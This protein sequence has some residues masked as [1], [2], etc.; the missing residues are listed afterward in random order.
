MCR[1]RY[2]KLLVILKGMVLA[3]YEVKENKK[4]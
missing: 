1:I 2:E 4:L 3:A